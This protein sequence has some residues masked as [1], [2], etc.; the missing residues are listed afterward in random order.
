MYY[1]KKI[2]MCCPYCGANQVV[3]RYISE[4]H[5]IISYEMC[6]YCGKEFKWY[7]EKNKYEF[8]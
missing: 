3:N 1:W 4:K 7:I 2:K 8:Y 5:S 6:W